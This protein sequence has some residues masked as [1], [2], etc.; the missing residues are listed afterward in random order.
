[1]FTYGYV[2]EATLAHLDLDETEAQAS[3]L[4]ARFHIFANEA[5]QA[6]CASKPKY[7]Y[8]DV[9]VV[10]KY[11]PLVMDTSG[12]FLRPPTDKELLD[13]NTIYVNETLT[14]QYWNDRNIYKR[15]EIVSM[16]DT[17][18]AFAFKKPFK[19]VEIKPTVTEQLE[20]EAF[21][22]ELKAHYDKSEAKEQQDF[23]YIGKNQLKFYKTGQYLIPAKF[24]WFKFDSAMSDSDEIDIPSDILMTIPLYIA[25][26]CLQ[27]DNM[28]KAQIVRQEF[29][30]AL[31]RCTAT[32]FMPLPT[33]EKSW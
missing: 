30:L 17:F 7:Q 25:S 11:A 33:I 15:G 24:M 2:R 10:D 21:G 31:G 16:A 3:N 19:I 9:T 13:K 18:I 4:L 26:V 22:Y 1:M 8:I 5:M 14:K 28:Q 23:A 32:D 27:I 6:I 12:A 20:A 29:E